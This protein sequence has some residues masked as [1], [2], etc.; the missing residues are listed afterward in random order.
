MDNKIMEKTIETIGNVT[1]VAANLSDA[2]KKEPE[3]KSDNKSNASGGSN[4]IQ[5]H[6]DTGNKKE[7]RPIEKHIHE[8]PESR[9]LTNE[10]CELALKKAQ[11]DFNLRKCEQDYFQYQDKREYEH[12]REL[13]RK[14]E[15]RS[16]IKFAIASIFCVGAAGY[17]GYSAY[18]EYKRNKFAPAPK[19]PEAS[20]APVNTEG[21]VE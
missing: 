12:Q 14:R 11:M 8:F 18:S 2:S 15:K 19:L 20:P 5:L 3:R 17:F 16:K 1:K 13:E 21:T 9:P 6:V 4:N 7:P 10:E